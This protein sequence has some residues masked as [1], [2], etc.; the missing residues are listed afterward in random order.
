MSIIEFSVKRRIA[1]TMFTLIIVLFGLLAFR[2]L[3][4]DLFPEIESPYITIITTYEGVGSEEIETGITRPIEEFVGSVAGVKTLNSISSEGISTITIE[5]NWGVN[6]DAAA[7]DVREKLSWVTEYLPKDADTPMVMKFN[8]TNMPII[9]YGVTGLEN[10]MKLREYLRSNVKTKLERLDGIS[11]VGLWGGKEREIQILLDPAKLKVTGISL[12]QIKTA[13]LYSNL[14][15]SGGHVN[16]DQKEYL[17][18]TSG[19]FDNLDQI[20]GIVVN[21]TKDGQIVHLSDIAEV[22]DGFKEIRG[23]ER[24]NREPTVILYVM[25]QSGANTVKA[26]DAVLEKMKEIEKSAPPS[27]KFFLVYNTGSIIKNSI[28]N[29]GKD[30]VLGGII[31]IFVVFI[32][33]KAFRATVAIALAIPLS[34][35]TTFIGMNWLG[36]TFNIMTLGGLT[37]AVGLVV[38]DAIVV[39]EN[40]FRHLEQGKPRDVAAIDGA[41]EVI[42]A[43]SASTFTTMAVFIPLSLAKN[44]AGM[45]ARPLSFTVCLALAASLVVAFTIIPAIAASLFKKEKEVYENIEEKGWVKK[46]NDKYEEL[47]A[48]AL[49]HKR[50]VLGV[51]FALL[52][53]SL[54]L[55]K[56]LGGDFMPKGD[57]SIY[58]LHITLP[59]GSLLSE[60]NHVTKQIEE[61]FLARPEVI[62]VVSQV[63]QS[64]SSKLSGQDS[65]V[66]KSTIY[67]RFKS[68]DD[69]NKAMDVI[70]NEVRN[71]FPKLQGVDYRFE[72]PAV[73]LMGGD[74]SPIL[75]DVIGP[76]L[77]VLD[78]LSNEMMDKM[79]TVPGLK[80]LKKSLKKRKPELHI[81]VDREEAARLGLSVYHI[82]DA[83]QTAMQGTTVS[84]FREGGKEY[85][86]MVKFNDEGNNSFDA[87][88]NVYVQSPMAAQV[89]ASYP[90]LNLNTV[91][92]VSQVTKIAKTYGPISILRKNHE[93]VVTIGATNFKRDID[94]ITK[95]VKAVLNTIKIPEGYTYEIGGQ[96]EQMKKSQRDLGL[97]FLVAV[98]LIYMIMAAQFESLSQPF[99]VMFTMPLAFIGVVFGL[100]LTG[101]HLSVPSIMGLIILMG[102]VVKNG[103]VMIDYINQL[104]LKGV[105]KT[106]AI[107]R[108]AGIRLRPV[109]MTSLTAIVGMLPMAFSRGEGSETSSPMALSV[110]FGLLVST[111]LTL[112]VIPSIY[113]IVEDYTPRI[114]HWI[115][116]KLFGEEDFMGHDDRVHR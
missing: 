67:I 71:H 56:L 12:Q 6:I 53:V 94:S 24:A 44:I 100:L 64:Q 98:L 34:I 59:E 27:V 66:N 17:I 84:F 86:I 39:I 11:Q 63:G 79:A 78:K 73:N 104:R 36:Y 109:L 83:I 18:R 60:T 68:K 9:E 3:G 42:M 111:M 114:R 47:L 41:K 32:F 89:A 75:I 2:D 99:V 57:Y 22:K 95:D 21:T 116:R 35:I 91:I 106:E 43:V 70:V 55:T 72:D 97:A 80:D 96:Y 103:I 69:R 15:M 40:T 112:F 110:S 81:Q 38:D 74:S 25:K 48:I 16:I 10:T 37:L 54:L 88:K 87:L 4:I 77:D 62:G 52:V 46:L 50:R 85:D 105:E 31:A 92:P 58:A 45:L 115:N 82:A 19:Y 108:G 107:I 28:S 90:S 33:L 101:N 65:G 20:R 76:D 8:I 26:T 102:I 113:S 5:F 1:I 61:M 23:E 51:A 93:R 13:I 14:S 7:Q 49:R 29:T 30:G